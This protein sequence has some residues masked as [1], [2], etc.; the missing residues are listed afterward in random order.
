MM[1][2][3]RTRSSGRLRL[4]G[5]LAAGLLAAA[6]VTASASAVVGG[7]P[8]NGAHPYVGMVAFLY[9]TPDGVSAELCSG[10]LLS[11]TVFVTAAHCV[12]P[13]SLQVAT[14]VTFVEAD[15]ITALHDGPYVVGHATVDPQFCAGCG[16]RA[17]RASTRT[18]SRSCRSTRRRS[19]TTRTIRRTYAQLPALGQADTLSNKAMVDIVG[20]GLPAIGNRT[21]APARVDPGRRQDGRRVP[22]A[23]VERLDRARAR[24]AAATRAVP[25]CSRAP[26][27]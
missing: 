14:L 6:L 2:S 9:Q 12:P 10:S 24:P 22:E 18:T 4:A 25:T 19:P 20:Y 8:D 5:I 21:T 3:I 26:T 23:L 16:T 1:E 7:R 11:A 17:R 13:E 27:R 15:A